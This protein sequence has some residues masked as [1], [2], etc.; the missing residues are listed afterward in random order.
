MYRP[1][2]FLLLVGWLL[3]PTAQASETRSSSLYSQ[4][5]ESIY[6]IQVINRQTGNKST[7]GSGF[8]VERDDVL[9]TNYH[10]I[11]E[12]VNDP[13][14][15]RLEY[16][17]T[18][19]QTGELEL[20]DVDV[21]HDLAVLKA[22][23]TLGTPLETDTVPEKGAEL[24]SL[25][26]PL[27]LGFSIV[28]GINNGILNHSEDNNIHFSGNLNPG[29][30]GGPALNDDG[31]VIGINVA[32]AGNDVS[33]LV[34]AQY[35]DLLLERIR[36]RGYKPPIDLHGSI[37]TQ[38][39]Q[40]SV[41]IL[42]RLAQ[43][44]WNMIRIGHFEVPAEMGLSISCWDN[45]DSEPEERGLLSI[46][47][48]QCSND[49]RIYLNKKLSV[50]SLQYQ[51]TW[52]EGR[53]MTS[54]RFYRNYENQNNSGLNVH[55]DKRNVSAF[56]CRTQFVD[57]SSKDFKMTVCKRD[58]RRYRGLSDVLVTGAMVGE[59]NRGM[60]FDIYMPGTDFNSTLQLLKR[61]L[62]SFQWRN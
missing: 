44:E 58:Y 21:L 36:L 42:E 32:T 24:F 1:I 40:K 43:N 57:V 5:E 27:D 38:L 50:G 22:P 17:S 7:I 28:R 26:N 34:S 29:M 35:L 25:G 31:K 14:S 46:Y 6:Q 41:E 53:N 59:K 9:A 18:S 56:D 10:V 12:F 16:F 4:A 55:S 54:P 62:G 23:Q 45:S 19:G 13:A 60:L 48:A 33:F 8:V 37:T 11:S 61:M 52:Y 39:S 47:A 51:Y 20:L 15:F 30:S 3:L 2:L 49:F